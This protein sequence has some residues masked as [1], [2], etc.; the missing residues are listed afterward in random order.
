MRGVIVSRLKDTEIPFWS[1]NF[2]MIL[3]S[4]R[5][6]LNQLEVYDDKLIKDTRFFHSPEQHEKVHDMMESSWKQ[7]NTH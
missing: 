2:Q 1:L 6:L 4:S 3:V 7:P 5:G